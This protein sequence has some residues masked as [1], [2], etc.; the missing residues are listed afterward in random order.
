MNKNNIHYFRFFIVKLRYMNYLF[1][2]SEKKTNLIFSQNASN[3]KFFLFFCFK[4]MSHKKEDILFII[5]SVY[6]D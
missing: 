4:K 3:K 1:F 2:E 5:F 6:K